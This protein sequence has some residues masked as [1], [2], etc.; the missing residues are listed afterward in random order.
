ME[1]RTYVFLIEFETEEEPIINL[2]G[3]VSQAM[4]E[5][6]LPSVVKNI[7]I[8]DL[9]E[10]DRV[11]LPEIHKSDPHGRAP[12]PSVKAII[13]QVNYLQDVMMVEVDKE[14]RLPDEHDGLQELSISNSGV[15]LL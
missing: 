9:K 2:L 8:R 14:D 7:G 13:L 15:T 4:T 12:C 1:K 3:K 6:G 10:G 11:R 5:G